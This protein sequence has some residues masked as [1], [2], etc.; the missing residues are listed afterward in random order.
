[1]SIP[2]TAIKIITR[3]STISNDMG[4]KNTDKTVHANPKIAIL[5]VHNTTVLNFFIFYTLS[6]S[7]VESKE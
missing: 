6:L 4:I 3:K 5:S 7:F 2:R 1:M